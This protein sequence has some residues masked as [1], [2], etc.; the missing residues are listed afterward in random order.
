MGILSGE[1]GGFDVDG[2]GSLPVGPGH[3]RPAHA[4]FDAGRI[5]FGHYAGQTIEELAER[6]PDY[7]RWLA[8]HPSGARYRAEIERILGPLSM[9]PGL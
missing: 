5:D 2:E 7:L 8:R 9:V 3:E 6:D 1:H 4:S